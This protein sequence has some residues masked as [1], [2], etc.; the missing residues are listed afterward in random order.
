MGRC[1]GE[2]P[3]PIGQSRAEKLEVHP[4]NH[5]Q[6]EARLLKAIAHPVRLQI[7]QALA[8]EPSCVCDL[9]L[10]IKRSQPYVSQHLM[11]LRDVGLVTGVREGW[12]VRYYLTHPELKTLL[13]SIYPICQS[14]DKTLKGPSRCAQP[15]ELCDIGA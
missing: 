1:S 5:Y 12:N 9:M 14:S 7:L 6:C 3:N 8:R 4:M 13:D 11:V 10:I 2:P 15:I